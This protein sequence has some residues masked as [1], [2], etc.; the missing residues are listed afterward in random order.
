MLHLWCDPSS[1]HYVSFTLALCSCWYLSCCRGITNVNAEMHTRNG[2]ART[3]LGPS[4]CSPKRRSQWS[5]ARPH[6]AE[7]NQTF[8]TRLETQWRCIR[9][10]SLRAD[11]EP[12]KTVSLHCCHRSSGCKALIIVCL[13]TTRLANLTSMC[14]AITVRCCD[15]VLK[16][17]SA[18]SFAPRD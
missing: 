2:V 9:F 18:P 1:G 6:I 17:L 8:V 13:A 14:F 11:A 7:V 12:S 10:E 5:K 3:M 4:G 15:V 16:C